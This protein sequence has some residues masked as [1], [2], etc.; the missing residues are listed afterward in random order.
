MAMIKGTLPIRNQFNMLHT[1]VIIFLVNKLEKKPQSLFTSQTI[2]SRSQ[3]CSACVERLVNFE[4][5]AFRCLI[6]DRESSI[7]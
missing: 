7:D 4:D 1:Q 6:E 2:K 3:R 5:S